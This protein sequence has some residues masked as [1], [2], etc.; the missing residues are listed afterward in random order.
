M[1]AAIASA[2]DNAGMSDAIQDE[3]RPSI[4]REEVAQLLISC[5]TGDAAAFRRLYEIQAAQL[6]GVALRIT[7]QPALAS[8]AVHDAL[9][10]VWRN[11]ER[12][13]P[14]RGS[15]RAW[16]TSLVRYRAMDAARK[17]RREISGAEQDDR[18][19]TDPDPLDRL[20]SSQDGQALHRC[21]KGVPDERRRLVTMAFVEGLTHA[22]IATRLRQPLGTVK[23][24]IRRA[25]VAL[26]IC[27]DGS[28]P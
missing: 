28:A 24:T 3:S 9:L 7:R 11:A 1:L 26:R 22:E 14:A 12:F 19:D 4:P 27:L 20:L 8:D 10:Q 17:T 25:L 13:D 23:S 18:P 2:G 21:M 6:Y 16:L 5:A 15:A